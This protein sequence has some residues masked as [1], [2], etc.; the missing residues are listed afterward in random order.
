VLA[1]QIEMLK[2]ERAFVRTI[3]DGIRL[4]MDLRN[5][6]TEVLFELFPWLKNEL[7]QPVTTIISTS[8][9]DGLQHQLERLEQLILQQGAIPI[10]IPMQA[11]RTQESG[12][13]ALSVPQFSVPDPDDDDTVILK[14]DTSTSSAMNFINSMLNLQQ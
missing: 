1:D 9:D 5:G 11:Q 14:C 10:D 8:P 3:R 4:I 7:S 6:R 2:N 12:P 13:K